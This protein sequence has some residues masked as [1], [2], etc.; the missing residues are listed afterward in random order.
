MAKKGKQKYG[1]SLIPKT[2]SP[3]SAIPR[4]A[5]IDADL[6]FCFKEM[7]LFCEKYSIKKAP[8]N[9]LVDFLTRMKDISSIPFQEFLGVTPSR[10]PKSLR[11]HLITFSGTSEPH[12]FKQL[13]HSDWAEKPWQFQ[14][15]KNRGRIIGYLRGSLFHVVWLDM[16]H[17]LYP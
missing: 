10:N 11:S 2:S 1:S 3:V 16:D 5:P 17:L 8:E 7:D 9:F 6:V 4:P 14:I 12:G 15:S 13:K